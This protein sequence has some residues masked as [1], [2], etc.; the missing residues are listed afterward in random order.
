M[1]FEPQD[2]T[3]QTKAE[4]NVSLCPLQKI[5]LKNEKFYEDRVRKIALNTSSVCSVP[6]NVT[7]FISGWRFASSV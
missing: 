7:H 2:Q 4:S 3:C 6:S 5:L 1:P